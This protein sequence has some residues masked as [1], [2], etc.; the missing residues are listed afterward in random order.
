MT[1]SVAPDEF[2]CQ[3]RYGTLRGL[4]WGR[5]DLPVILALH[6]WLDNAASF[7]RLAPLLSG[8]QV[9]APDLPG[10]GHSDWLGPGADYSIWS[11]VEALHDLIGQLP[12]EQAP[13]LIGHSMGAAAG[14]LFGGAFPDQ[15][16][17]Y[18]ALDAIGPLVTP[19]L[20]APQQLAD[21]IMAHGPRRPAR[22]YGSAE[23][24]L[25][26]RLRQNQELNAD[27]IGPVVLRNLQNS[28]EG[29]SWRTDPRLRDPSRVRL[30]EEQVQAFM[31]RMQLPSLV[32]RAE[33]GL[34][35]TA[36]FDLRLSYLTDSRY[37]QLPGH[38]HFHLERGTVDGVAAGIR[39]FLQ[40]IQA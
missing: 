13:V 3:C 32:V 17:A 22:V 29:V 15:L 18:I 39:H 24:A 1:H 2:S 6:G 19:P 38:H 34:I 8:Y 9:I 25:A 14:L 27:C 4:R 12:A 37:Q 31:Q 5:P 10:H 33:G 28:G 30:T 36:M 26:A 16:S 20:Q 7:T 35:P 11:G 40:E 23:E 21:A